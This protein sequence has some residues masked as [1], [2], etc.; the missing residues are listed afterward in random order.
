MLLGVGARGRRGQIPLPQASLDA[1]K[2][3]KNR[4]KE[5]RDALAKVHGVRRAHLASMGSS[6]TSGGRNTFRSV[7]S[8]LPSPRWTTPSSC[9]ARLHATGRTLTGPAGIAGVMSAAMDERLEPSIW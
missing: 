1:K 4:M 5:L 8:S 2:E 7:R 9:V 3:V 6:L